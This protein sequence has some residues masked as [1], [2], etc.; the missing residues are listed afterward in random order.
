MPVSGVVERGTRVVGERA[1][2]TQSLI[3]H[4]AQ[5]LPRRHSLDPV[6]LLMACGSRILILA[7]AEE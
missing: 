5:D 2:A 6:V 7:H 3:V 4:G 1:G